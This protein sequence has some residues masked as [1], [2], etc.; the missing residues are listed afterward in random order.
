MKKTINQYLKSF[1]AAW[2]A[3]VTARIKAAKLYAEAANTKQNGV[4][5]QFWM[6]PGFENWSEAK[7][8]L[9]YH[10]GNGDVSPVFIDVDDPSVPISMHTHN[11]TIQLQEDIFNN[12]MTVATLTGRTKHLNYNKLQQHHIDLKYKNKKE[13]PEDATFYVERTHQEQL[14]WLASRERSNVYVRQDGDIQVSHGCRITKQQL[15]SLLSGGPSGN[16]PIPLGI[17]AHQVII[18]RI[19]RRMQNNG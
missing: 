19:A 17:E 3:S 12:G 13:L 14:D 4:K 1:T 18:T 7:W 15:I 5:A 6:L 11:L 10:I 9:L 16:D 2:G 8:S